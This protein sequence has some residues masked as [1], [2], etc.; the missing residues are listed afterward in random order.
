M[1]QAIVGVEILKY[2]QCL[3]M[4]RILLKKYLGERSMNLLKRKFESFTSI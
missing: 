3:K 4:H 1:D 2:W